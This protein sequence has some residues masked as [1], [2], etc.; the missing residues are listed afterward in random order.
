VIS[1][2][3]RIVRF[4]SFIIILALV[5]LVSVPTALG[6]AGVWGITH[7]SCD[8]DMNPA[9]Y[10]MADYEEVT[11]RA[12]ALDRD[13]RGYFVRAANSNGSTIIVAP[14]GGSGLGY[15]RQESIVLVQ[16][17]YN[18]FNYESR[19]CLG[20]P[21][22][23]GIHEASEVGDALAYLGT[24]LDVDME[25]I[26][27]TGFSAGG[28]TA[29]FAAAQYPALRALVAEGG[30]YDFYALI[31]DLA[32]DYW[33][34]ELYRFGSDIAYRASVHL[35]LSSLSPISVIDEIAPRQI[36]LIYGS[37][38]SSLPGARKQ[39]AAAGEN[40]ELWEV[41]NGTHGSYWIHAPEEYERRITNF[42][43]RALGNDF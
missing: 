4:T 23:L 35:P 13:V 22:S 3:K 17:G 5:M 41:P 25:R 34:G 21:N 26:G 31:D 1:N 12:S 39:A 29:T 32:G 42:F 11:F 8:A 18:L 38:E 40:A 43:D 30:F 7:A 9:D 33:F 15:W 2:R 16:H 37:R 19:N 36:L 24:R 14:T 6:F 10:G 27:I 20:Y 28:A